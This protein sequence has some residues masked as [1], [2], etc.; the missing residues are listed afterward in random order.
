[1]KTSAFLTVLACTS[2]VACHSPQAATQTGPKVPPGQVWLTPDQ[3]TKDGIQTVMVDTRDV[4]ATLMTSGRVT[5]DDLRVAHIYSPVSGKVVRIDAQLGARVKK[6]DVLA[7][8][9]S[10]D[11]GNAASDL[12][13]AQADEIAAE[14]AYKRAKDLSAQRAGTTSDLET[15]EDAFRQSRAELERA[16]QKAYLLRTGAANGVTQTYTL[17][18]PIEGEVVMRNLNPGVEVQGQYGGNV[19]NEL[20]TV[21]ELDSVWVLADLYEVDLARAKLGAVCTV[22]TVAYRDKAFVG[23]VDWISGTLDPSTR[24]ARV[25][26]TLANPDG[27]LKPEM[28]ATAMIAVEQRRALAVPKDAVTRLGD[29]SVAFIKIGESD[30]KVKFER[31]PVSVDEAESNGVCVVQHGLEAGQEVVIAGNDKLAAEL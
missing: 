28:Y 15:A 14:H 4:D 10:P 20:F 16:Q 29:S 11:I 13:K 6:G 5:F 8:I 7:V 31:L 9:E 3:V 27:F 22:T 23:K 24:T 1:M 2:A 21:G 25:R 17:I 18:A 12:G 26:C 30:G 19:V